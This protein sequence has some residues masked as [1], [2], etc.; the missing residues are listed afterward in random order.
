MSA[1]QEDAL[2]PDAPGRPM[3]AWGVALVVGACLICAFGLL[4]LCLH[5]RQQAQGGST[6]PAL[7]PGS[8]PTPPSAAGVSKAP[9]R[10]A[11][12]QMAKARASFRADSF[13][14]D[15]FRADSFRQ[16]DEEDE[17]LKSTAADAP[18]GVSTTHSVELV[19]IHLGD[20][21]GRVVTAHV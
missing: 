17:P 11:I 5:M 4:G 18:R 15:S 13:R 12:E 14:A 16:L 21:H 6:K 8:P 7:W 3:P 2:L 19:D 9:A 1:D 10:V 20:A